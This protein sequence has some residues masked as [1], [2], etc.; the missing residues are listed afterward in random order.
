[1]Q[2]KFNQ[3]VSVALVFLLCT[4]GLIPEAKGEHINDRQSIVARED[5]DD[6]NNESQLQGIPLEVSEIA[7]QITVR[8]DSGHGNGSGVIFARQKDKTD[9]DLFVYYVLTAKHVVEKNQ[10]YTLTAEDGESYPISSE[11]KKFIDSDLAVVKFKSEAEYNTAR[12]GDY[13][14]GFNEEAWVFVYGWANT[15]SPQPQFSTGKIAGKETGIFLV[16]D[17][18]SFAQ[19]NGYELVYTNLSESGMSGGP[20]LDTSGRVIGIHASAEGERY[21]LVNNLQLGFSLGVPVRTFLNSE[22]ARDLSV[23]QEVEIKTTKER[24]DIDPFTQPELSQEDLKSIQNNLTEV[25][26]PNSS[27]NETEWLNHGNQL[28]RLSRY[29]EAIAA[30]DRAL[31][32]QPD[33]YQAH[34]GKGLA[35]YN[36]GN[37]QVAVADFKQATEIEPDFYPAWYRLSLCL[38]ALKQYEPAQS[39][40]K[41]AIALKPDNVALYILQGEA[42]QNLSRPQE[43]IAVYDKAIASDA[44]S[45]VL[46]RRGSLYRNLEKY[47]LALQDFN[48]ATNFNPK[49]IEAYINRGLTYYQL[50]NYAQALDDFNHAISLDDRDPRGYLARGLVNY[51]Q[52]EL[53]QSTADFY[54]AWQTYQQEQATQTEVS[55]VSSQPDKYAQIPIDFDHLLQAD[56]TSGHFDFGKGVALALMGE[57][58]KAIAHLQEASSFFQSQQD[59][60]SYQLSQAL[61][62][63]IDQ[64]QA[65]NK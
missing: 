64:S 11:I 42:L 4:F 49:Y 44:S 8:I 38:L 57:Q 3:S 25:Q 30:F 59:N 62:Q 45:I 16:K 7:E 13:K 34:Y 35:H 47:D 2:V 56:S 43:A 28:W 6:E 5:R 39:A 21:K 40:I 51:Q 17:D 33:F 50:G 29:S 20:V 52:G 37:Y 26:A 60:S 58:D 54:L 61:L 15:S 31:E 36:Q 63:Q 1:M 46:V 12:F 32:K 22:Y 41:Q 27:S 53:N 48:R 14:F 55:N 24:L 65:T 9:K 19:D 23:K 18:L 10:Q